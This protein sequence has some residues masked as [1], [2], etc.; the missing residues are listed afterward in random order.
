MGEAT[1]AIHPDDARRQNIGDGA[2]VTLS[3]AA[4]CLT[5]KAV[6]SDIIPAGALLTDKSRWPG[7]E[8]GSNVNVLHVPQKTDMGESTS[9]HGVEVEIFSH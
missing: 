1:V 2:A 7:K 6:I 9:V 8:G 5:L 4:G 3:N